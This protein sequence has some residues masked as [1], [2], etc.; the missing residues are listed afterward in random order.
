MKQ[1]VYPI[2]FNYYNFPKSVYTS[3]NVVIGHGG[4]PLL[5]CCCGVETLRTVRLNSLY[6]LQASSM[7]IKRDLLLQ[8]LNEIIGNFFQLFRD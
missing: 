5:E 1:D 4:C 3:I 8:K 2:P 6:R 7:S